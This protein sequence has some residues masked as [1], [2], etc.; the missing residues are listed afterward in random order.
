M[1][2]GTLGGLRIQCHGYPVCKIR[3]VL[4]RRSGGANSLSLHCGVCRV[5][6]REYVVLWVWVEILH[7]VSIENNIFDD[8]FRIFL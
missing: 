7:V 8:W 5:S 2:T 1:F 6:V 3:R 4:P